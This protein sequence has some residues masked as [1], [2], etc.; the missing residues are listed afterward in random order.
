MK[1]EL[2]VT[3]NYEMSCTDFYTAVV[4]DK[5]LLATARDKKNGENRLYGSVYAVIIKWQIHIA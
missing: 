4:K 5:K 3:L 2:I 1:S